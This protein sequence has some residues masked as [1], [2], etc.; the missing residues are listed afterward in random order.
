LPHQSGIVSE[1]VYKRPGLVGKE[2]KGMTLA[3]P[4]GTQKTRFFPNLGVPQI[5]PQEDAEPRAIR[6][7]Q[8]GQPIEDTSEISSC[9][10]CDS[11]NFEG[12][13]F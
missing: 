4:T 7:R 2:P 3:F 1:L 13:V 8:C 5:I 9:P 6:C 11:D 10:G 12:R